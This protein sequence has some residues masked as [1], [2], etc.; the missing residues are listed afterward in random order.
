[1]SELQGST[2]GISS[3]WEKV[4]DKERIALTPHMGME[5]GAGRSF[6]KSLRGPDHPAD[7]WF[8]KGHAIMETSKSKIFRV[9]Q[10]AGKS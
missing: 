10:Q 6:T 3:F 5:I 7:I 4:L 8:K 1:M 2:E 9:G